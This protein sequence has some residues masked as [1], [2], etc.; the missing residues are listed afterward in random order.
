MADLKYN[1]NIFTN[2]HKWDSE[3]TYLGIQVSGKLNQYNG[4]DYP[5]IDAI[6][7]DWDGAYVSKLNSYVY[8]TED[9]INLFNKLGE[10]NINND[11]N[12]STNYY[13]KTEFGEIFDDYKNVIENNFYQMTV[14]ME[15]TIL[16]NILNRYEFLNSITDILIDK[17]RYLEIPY[18][19]IV[20]NGHL[21]NYA[22][23]RTFFTFDDHTS[24]YSEITD[25]Q[26]II[27]H[28]DETYYIFIVSDII[29][30]NDDVEDIYS[31]IGS[32][33]YDN[34]NNSYS[35]TG[36][37]Q[38]F[39]VIETDLS[40]L[41]EY[42]NNNTEV[43]IEAYNYAYNSYILSNENKTKIGY[44]TR[45]N[46]YEKVENVTSPEF[47]NYLSS[48]ANNIFI[49]DP[50]DNSRYISIRYTGNP[51]Y[52]YY[53]L[54][55]KILGTG[56]EKEIEDINTAIGD[57]SYL[58]YHLQTESKT[59]YIK[60]NITPSN[61]FNRT[62][63]RTIVLDISNSYV[64]DTGEITNGLVNHNTMIDGVSYLLGWKILK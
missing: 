19:N 29:K 7:I 8:T 58:L 59:S 23:D 11:I 31:I 49:K 38:R 39:N 32:K 36:F 25:K 3:Y 30:L 40:Y 54:H 50:N 52:E 33:Y 64:Y 27:D 17:T 60:L 21:T 1:H 12:L 2:V 24:L 14:D 45:Y 18:E 55:E 16:Q 57:N 34:T 37:Y 43:T 10:Y 13:N 20:V 9:L 46:V 63:D 4:Q 22:Q 42:L 6:D 62:I 26:Y 15:E 56:I 44:H 47:I 61:D 48:H 53:I 28:P 5:I 41:T 51:N 35:Y